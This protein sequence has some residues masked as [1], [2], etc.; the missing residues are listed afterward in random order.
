LKESVR[1]QLIGIEGLYKGQDFPLRKDAVIIG[2]D[3]ECDIIFNDKKTSR[4]HAR[5]EWNSPHYW[6]QD[7]KSTNGIF[8]NGFPVNRSR[9][10]NGDKVVIGGTVFLLKDEMA[11]HICEDPSSAVLIDESLPLKER[12]T[13][14]FSPKKAHKIS[15]EDKKEM[16]RAELERNYEKY[17]IMLKIANALASAFDLSEIL[18]KIMIEIFAIFPV[19]RGVIMLLDEDTKEYVPKVVWTRDKEPS[20]KEI[21]ISKTLIDKVINEK[22]AV[23]TSDIRSESLFT[24]SESILFSAIKSVMCVPIIC[25]EEVLGLIQVDTKTSRHTFSKYDLELFT[26]LSYQAAIA[27]ENAS[28]YKKIEE[29]IKIRANLSR[30][31]PANLVD[32]V[33]SERIG[34]GLGGELSNV[35]ILFSDIR[36]FTRMSENMKPQ[37]TVQLLNEYL[38]AMNEV[39]FEYHGM[40]DKFIGDAIMAIFGGPWVEGDGAE[41]AVNTAIAMIEVLGELNNKW[42]MEGRPELHIGI[43]INQGKVVLGNIGSH[44][45]M[46]YTAIGDTVNTASR[47]V[48]IAGKDEI[49]ISE[50]LF[51]ILKEKFNFHNLPPAEV[52]GKEKPLNIMV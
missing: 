46:E 13:I 43:G 31:L 1:C 9:L 33:I 38:T 14:F 6:I 39:V 5:L 48:S 44:A 49:I 51:E 52:K 28:L 10:Q 23:S 34:L 18:K 27:I 29:E 45:R 19:D 50:S 8:V 2:R 3:A 11:P 24:K 40:I 20:K 25:K 26:A 15:T 41:D 30:Y 12:N 47:L 36:G 35:T 42:T 37:E 17:A 7:L 32:D 16:E 21:V 4:K 22:Q